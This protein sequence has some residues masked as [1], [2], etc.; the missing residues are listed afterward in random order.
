MQQD[1]LP[2]KE[3]QEHRPAAWPGGELA[4]KLMV[5]EPLL[6]KACRNNRKPPP[7]GP[8]TS[9]KSRQ[10]GVLSQATGGQGLGTWKVLKTIHFKIEK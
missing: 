3:K 8:N 10:D 2:C 4:W 6:G 5:F 9:R 7:H 1:T